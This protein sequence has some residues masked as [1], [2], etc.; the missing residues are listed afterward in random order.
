MLEVTGDRWQVTAAQWQVT[1]DRWQLTGDSWPSPWHIAWS[2]PNLDPGPGIPG[3]RAQ[4]RLSAKDPAYGR[5]LQVYRWMDVNLVEKLRN[6]VFFHTV[7]A[8]VVIPTPIVL[9]ASSH[10]NNSCHYDWQFW[11]FDS[12]DSL[13]VLTVLN[14]SDRHQE[15]RKEPPGKSK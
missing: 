14:L 12:F 1:G 8:L 2:E 6:P 7:F 10:L 9:I 11:Q 3:K 13:K 4:V 15:K 5:P